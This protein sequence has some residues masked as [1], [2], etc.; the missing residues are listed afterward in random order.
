MLEAAWTYPFEWLLNRHPTCEVPFRE[1]RFAALAILLP[2]A[3][4]VAISR[5]HPKSRLKPRTQS[6]GDNHRFWLLMLFF[7]ISYV[8]WLWQFAIQRYAFPL[9][10]LAGV[11]LVI[12]LG[13]IVENVRWNLVACA[14]IAAFI[15][16]WTR[17]PDWGRVPYGQDWFA[18]PSSHRQSR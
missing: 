12:A 8:V 9:E 1:A 4:I 10:L 18:I 11:I 2:V 6:N 7:S 13:T 14:A 17:P 15:V 3:A 16:A 5:S